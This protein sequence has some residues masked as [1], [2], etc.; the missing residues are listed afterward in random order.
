M[1]YGTRFN[2][3]LLYF[4]TAMSPA[5]FLFL[6]QVNEKFDQPFDKVIYGLNFNI[7]VWCAIL[8]TFVVILAL[9]LK[10]LLYIQYT[11]G[12]GT[13]VMPN[14]FQKFSESN[15]EESNGNVISFL[16]GNIIPV[17]L[18]MENSINEAIIVFIILQLII[19]ILIMK[20]SDLFPNILLI[21][22]GVDLCKTKDGNYLF[23][24]KGKNVN[25]E[26]VYQ[27]G[28]AGKSKIYITAYKK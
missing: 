8:F 24:F 12:L 17:V 7:Y 19:F 9:T 27:L 2:Y 25:V 3:N 14:K 5:Y 11:K 18:I 15:I 10:K 21:I 16:L 6:L 22:L 20:S 28:D 23:I 1:F 4:I 26:K 13:P